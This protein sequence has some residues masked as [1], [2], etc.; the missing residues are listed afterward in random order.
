VQCGGLLVS[1]DEVVKWVAAKLQA[2]DE[3]TIKLV[4]T[5]SANTPIDRQKFNPR[6]VPES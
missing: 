2:G 3:I 5:E 6:D 4:E 1:G